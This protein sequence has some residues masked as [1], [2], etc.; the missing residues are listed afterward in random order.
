[1]SE[2]WKCGRGN[3]AKR[4]EIEARTGQ[5]EGSILIVMKSKLNS[6]LGK[7]G[8]ALV[9][10][11]IFQPA[12]VLGQS[13]DAAKVASLIE[14]LSNWGRWGAD[15][16][17]GTLNLITPEVRVQAAKQVREGTSVSMAHNAD[18]KLSV[19]NSTPYSHNM[20][21][22][23]E[24][25]QDGVWAMDQICV[26]YHG[27]AHTHIDALCHL[28]N[29]GKM[30][31]GV[32][33]STVTK[34]GAEKLS[35]IGLKHGVFARGILLDIPAMKGVDWLEPG[36][37]V[38]VKDLEAFEK[39]A[40]L[41]IGKG[42]VVFLRTGRWAR[43]QAKGPW[44]IGSNS[45]GFHYSCMEWLAERD[46]AFIGSDAAG[47]VLPSG[48]DGVIAPVHVLALHSLGM[49]IF[50]NCD[51]LEVGR[52]CKKL[53]RYTF[54]LTANPLPVDGGTGSPLNPVATF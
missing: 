23:G 28:F 40:K 42:D 46:I 47:D 41:K 27:F 13:G 1:M 44:D 34:S 16:Q 33:Q 9:C 48:V 14:K 7:L 54:L 20:M 45:A 11:T 22:T 51:F 35:I 12:A 21:A 49:N 32:P 39:W 10:G 6:L 3:L 37:P 52:T 26:A 18:K 4:I 29:N 43:E 24:N 15:D 2:K 17:L 31:N 53:K 5:D 8:M 36:Y 38:T 30:Y 50:D 19:Y 25:P